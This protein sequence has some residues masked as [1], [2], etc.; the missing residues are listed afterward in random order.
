MT[1]FH[2]PHL[3]EHD[4]QCIVVL[5][6]HDLSTGILGNPARERNFPFAFTLGAEA[7]FD[8]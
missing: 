2:F 1:S 3:A 4:R 5:D 6:C 8:H 7:Q